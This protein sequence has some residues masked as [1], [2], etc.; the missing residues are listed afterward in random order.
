MRFSR[1]QYGIGCDFKHEIIEYRGNNCFI[2]TR[3]YCFVKCTIFVTA[4]DYKQQCL[5]FIR[6]EE[7]RSN[8]MTNA[9]I[10]PVC[11]A[12][13]ITLGYYDGERF[14]PRSVTDRN[15]ALFFFQ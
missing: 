8:I 3:G 12:N 5:N 15:N 1:S 9:G 11:C 10:Q 14:F 6:N 2:P 4:K 13:N 7:R